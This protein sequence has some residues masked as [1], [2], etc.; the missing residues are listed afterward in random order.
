MPTP[1]RIDLPET[2]GFLLLP[3][4]SMMAFVSA[5]EPL[6]V[7]NRLAGAMLYQWEIVSL[8]GASI[9][10]SNG[11]ALVADRQLSQLSR[12]GARYRTVVVGAGFEPERG[13][14]RRVRDWLRRLDR[15][16][17]EL[18]A[19]DTGSFVLA[20]AGLLD[21]YRATTHWESLDSFRERFPKVEAEGGLFAIDRNRLTCAGGT[22]ALDMMLHLI[23]RRHGHRL[24][25]AVSEQFI[26]ARIRDPQD[27]Q[28]MEPAARQGVSHAGLGR[29]IALMEK[30]LE[31]PL[32]AARMARGAGLSQRQLERLFREHLKT[33]PQRYYLDLRLQRAR[34]LLQ[35][36]EMPVVEVAVACGFGSAA[37]FSRSYRT[38]SGRA[39]SAER[40]PRA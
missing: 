11:M 6:R 25:T 3:K 34:A 28:R 19:M 30:N 22:A 7:A 21:G 20:R 37:H 1:A 9:L 17:V 33:T 14:D 2:L 5:V 23:S 38:W 35:Y 26:H 13:Y 27:R 40:R 29:A 18:G 39:P 15:N 32:D 36:S 31:E 16:G 24:A 10:A 12:G 4:F 8:E